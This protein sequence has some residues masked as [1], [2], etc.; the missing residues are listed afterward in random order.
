ML[1]PH[2]R[3]WISQSWL[4]Y[5]GALI[6]S[7]NCALWAGWG[8]GCKSGEEGLW[9]NIEV[10]SQE[11]KGLCPSGKYEWVMG[12]GQEGC[13]VIN[14]KQREAWG[15]E[16]EGQVCSW[17]GCPSA[18]QNSPLTSLSEYTIPFRTQN[19]MNRQC[20]EMHQDVQETW[21]PR[22]NWELSEYSRKWAATQL[23]NSAN[24]YR[25]LQGLNKNH[26]VLR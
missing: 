23:N 10:S 22:V 20:K 3:K 9:D 13:S 21:S 12:K 11:C 26:S 14:R 2:W 19:T 7:T 24:Q 15:Y 16:H 4:Q 18:V 5:S 1:R 6:L 17:P 8:I 25:P